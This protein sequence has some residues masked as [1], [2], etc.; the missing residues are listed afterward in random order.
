[1][2]DQQPRDMPAM[3]GLI[4]GAQG[5]HPAYCPDGQYEG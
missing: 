1:M 3:R 4:V 5:R 2:I